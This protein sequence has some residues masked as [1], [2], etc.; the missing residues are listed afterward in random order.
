M[1]LIEVKKRCVTCLSDLGKKKGSHRFE[2]YNNRK[3]NFKFQ[4][5]VFV[6]TYFDNETV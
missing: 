2:T 4:L 6:S 1:L 5:K 3:K